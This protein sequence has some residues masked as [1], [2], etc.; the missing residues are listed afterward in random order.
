MKLFL[1][2]IIAVLAGALFLRHDASIVVPQKKGHARAE[3][4]RNHSCK[5]ESYTAPHPDWDFFEDAPTTAQGYWYYTCSD[6][7]TFL[8][9]DDE[10]Q[11]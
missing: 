4:V 1:I 5:K 2:C 8:I 3:Y 6:G 7:M 9:N 11:P 10:E